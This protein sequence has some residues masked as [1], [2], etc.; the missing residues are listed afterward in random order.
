MKIERAFPHESGIAE[1]CECECE[2]LVVSRVFNVFLFLV[3]F[4]YIRPRESNVHPTTTARSDFRLKTSLVAAAVQCVTPPHQLRSQAPI[5]SCSCSCGPQC[6]CS[7]RVYS[8]AR[9]HPCRVF[10][11]FEFLR[12]PGEWPSSFC[13]HVYRAMCPT[14]GVV[15][16]V[17]VGTVVWSLV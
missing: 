1:W 4:S 15:A 16:L 13:S 5:P 6:K 8:S 10:G 12:F 3:S 7:V 9:T 17:D 11:L 14:V 2:W